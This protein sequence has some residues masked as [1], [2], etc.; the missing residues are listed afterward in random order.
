MQTCEWMKLLKIVQCKWKDAHLSIKLEVQIGLFIP[1]Y[2][3]G[4]NGLNN[5][6]LDSR[7]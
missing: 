6:D 1:V 4:W 7:T 5:L 2:A 3:T